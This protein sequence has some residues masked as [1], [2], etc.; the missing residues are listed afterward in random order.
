VRFG[1][2]LDNLLTNAV[3]YTPTGGTVTLTAAADGDRVRLT[4]ADTG[5]GI[6]ADQ[7]PRVFERFFRVPEADHPSGTGLGLAIV[8][9]I[10]A[11][12]GGEIACR[13]EVGVGTAFTVT[14]PAWKE[15]T[16]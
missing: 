2:A 4:V 16:A 7:L 1:H 12:H 11:A 10:V 14:L 15:G 5:V 3:T 13:S 6:P 9:E 8:K